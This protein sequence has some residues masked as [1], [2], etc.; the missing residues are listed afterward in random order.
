MRPS[1]PIVWVF[2]KQTR[3]PSLLSPSFLCLG[4]L[5]V[6]VITSLWTTSSSPPLDF[7]RLGSHTFLSHCLLRPPVLPETRT[8]CS[9]SSVQHSPSRIFFWVL[10]SCRRFCSLLQTLVS[11]WLPPFL[12]LS[13]PISSLSLNKMVVCV[14]SSLL[15]E[16]PD[17]GP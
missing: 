7:V 11:P 8:R 16:H 6:S 17:C 9:S 3:L 14:P 15:V 1:D 2:L 10:P 12:C 13:S 4:S 5:V